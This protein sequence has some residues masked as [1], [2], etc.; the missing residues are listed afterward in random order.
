[1]FS[2]TAAA[3]NGVRPERLE[4]ERR[5]REQ[6]EMC[7]VPVAEPK[8]VAPPGP[9]PD[10]PARKVWTPEEKAVA[11]YMGETGLA[12]LNLRGAE[13]ALESLAAGGLPEAGAA[14]ALIREARAA[15]RAAVKAME[16]P[17]RAALLK[18]GS[19]LA[20]M[21]IRKLFGDDKGG[22]APAAASVRD[23]FPGNVGDPVLAGG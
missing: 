15:E 13:S 10:D 8:A 4:R 6:Q 22:A 19:P 23:P 20:G 17:V 14:L 2:E 3:T 21:V 1:M 11:E 5:A 18:S 9:G 7:G 12:A 16:R